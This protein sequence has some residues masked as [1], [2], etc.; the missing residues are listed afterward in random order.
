MQKLRLYNDFTVTPL[1]CSQWNVT[2]DISN[3]FVAVLFSVKQLCSQ[4]AKVR[5]L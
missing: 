1:K 2:L 3:P 5:K 4:V